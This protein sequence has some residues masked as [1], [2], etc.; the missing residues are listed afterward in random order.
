M[1]FAVFVLLAFAALTLSSVSASPAKS[2]EVSSDIG[3]CEEFMVIFN[4]CADQLEKLR[5]STSPP[6]TPDGKF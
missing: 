2:G 5:N 1:H 6:V 4:W 3:D